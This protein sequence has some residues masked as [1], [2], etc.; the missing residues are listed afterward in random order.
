M[1]LLSLLDNRDDILNPLPDNHEAAAADSIVDSMVDDTISTDSIVDDT[2]S[3]DSIVYDTVS[4]TQPR[5]S[6]LMS[7]DSEPNARQEMAEVVAAEMG[8]VSDESE[9]LRQS[10]KNDMSG[11]SHLEIT[12]EDE[13][14]LMSRE[15]PAEM[16]LHRLENAE[17]EENEEKVAKVDDEPATVDVD[18]VLS[19]SSYALQQSESTEMSE[20]EKEEEEDVND[21]GER[22]LIVLEIGKTFD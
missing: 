14:L 13:T 7:F 15:Q 6:S 16:S 12:S 1:I 10:D 19:N 5:E 3:T 17:N 21:L 22:C 11:V 9:I 20:E 18:S 4:T 2:V 8:E